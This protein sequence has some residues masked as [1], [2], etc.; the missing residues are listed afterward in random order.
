[1]ITFLR[2]ALKAVFLAAG[3]WLASTAASST[4]NA[5]EAVPAPLAEALA[6]VL[7]SPPVADLPLPP[8]PA[9]PALHAPAVAD[10]PLPPAPALPAP[11]TEA[12][13]PV[14]FGVL[15]PV[16]ASPPIPSGGLPE[17]GLIAVDVSAPINVCGTSITVIGD[18]SSTCEQTAT[19]PDSETTNDAPI[20]INVVAPVNVCGT[21][22][23]VV[24]NAGTTCSRAATPTVPTV[25]V[26]PTDPSTPT[27]PSA[28]NVPLQ[29]V[30]QSDPSG[31]LGI[32]RISSNSNLD[33]LPSTGAPLGIEALIGLMLL[34]FGLAIDRLIGRRVS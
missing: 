13:A 11:P 28:P 27:V 24:G 21:S 8:A 32:R 15:L 23:A 2:F 14:L 12:V 17:G 5:A 31:A 29:L 34:T 10:L 19:K 22:F 20:G 3:F 26:T 4:A 30:G 16:L 1:M 25:P 33:S 9:G 7:T 18:A 6:P